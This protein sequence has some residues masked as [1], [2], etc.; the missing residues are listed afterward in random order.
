VLVFGINTSGDLCPHFDLM[1]NIFFPTV[2][3]QLI[4][5]GSSMD[6]GFIPIPCTHHPLTSTVIKS[7][8]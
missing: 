6:W 7:S 5:S 2:V 1:M 4:N 8:I 3:D